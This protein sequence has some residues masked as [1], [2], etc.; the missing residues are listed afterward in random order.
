MNPLKPLL[1]LF[2][3][4][5]QTLQKRLIGFF[6]V[7]LVAVMAGLF[8]ILIITGVFSA[9]LK[10]SR[11]YLNNELSDLKGDIGNSCGT[12]AVE[13]IAL[14]KRL[15][16]QIAGSLAKQNR[17]PAD[18]SDSPNCL[19]LVL[20]ECLE[21]LKTS[22]YKNDVSGAFVILDATV[23]NALENSDYSRAGLFLKNMDPNAANRSD[24][25]IRYV[26]GPANIAREKGLTVLP[27][28]RMEFTTSEN[29]FFHKVVTRA[30]N[31]ELPL[32]RQYYWSPRAHLTDDYEDSLILV[33]PLV[34]EDRTVLGVCGFEV[35]SMLF[36]LQHAPD[37]T[38]Y[39]RSFSMLSP[40]EGQ[41]L[42][43]SKALLARNYAAVS[44]RIMGMMDI[45]AGTNGLSHFTTETGDIFDGVYQAVNLYPTDSAYAD[46]GWAVAVMVPHE[47]LSTYVNRQN[48]SLFTLLACLLLISAATAIVMSRR[49]LSPVLTA[50]RH[51][52]PPTVYRKTNIQ[53]IDDLFQFL[54]SQ[55]LPVSP[56]PE[57]IESEAHTTALF[58]TFLTNIHTLS[59]AE[60][61]VF[62]LYQEGYTAKE[63][64]EILCL[65][66]NTIKTHNKRIYMKLNVESR[67]ELMLY[68]NMLKEKNRA[69][70]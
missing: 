22:L 3:R 45:S 25:E 48:T 5:T 21:T 55:D 43:T 30:R 34:N 42:N 51:R 67:S 59:P 52:E 62:N 65:S 70:I 46:E 13:G 66:I 37:S 44:D 57:P 49:Y 26:R 53:E 68:L 14:S 8:L 11:A 63:I 40:L 54:A 6:L 18:L 28:W 4:E 23:N 64:A 69:L 50:L 56:I 38:L 15:S 7:F 47:D 19:N 16:D 27:Q 60:R 58:E 36:K 32:S 61:A 29:D 20:T 31:N 1:F 9:G 17:T 10:E 35:S 33:V 24:P 2:R 41:S 39:P 12:T